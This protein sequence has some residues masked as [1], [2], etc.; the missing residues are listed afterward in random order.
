MDWN[1]GRSGWFSDMKYQTST[2][3]GNGEDQVNN[4]GKLTIP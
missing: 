1:I 4:L 2:F 3:D